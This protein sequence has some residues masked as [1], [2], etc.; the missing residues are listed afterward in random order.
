MTDGTCLEVLKDELFFLQRLPLGWPWWSGDHV[1]SNQNQGPPVE[2]HRFFFLRYFFR[3]TLPKKGKRALLGDL[4]NHTARNG[5][6]DCAKG[7]LPNCAPPSVHVRFG[8]FDTG[9]V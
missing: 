5:L 1:A 9:S 2:G 6:I 3:G 7:E 4:E 8:W